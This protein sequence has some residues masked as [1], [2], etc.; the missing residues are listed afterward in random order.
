MIGLYLATV[1]IIK[2]IQNR[3]I[4]SDNFPNMVEANIP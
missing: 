3:I 2:S 1:R 4:K